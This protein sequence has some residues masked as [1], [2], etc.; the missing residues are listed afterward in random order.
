MTTAL[1]IKPG[2]YRTRGGEIVA[3]ESIKNGIAYTE[4]ECLVGLSWW[5]CNGSNNNFLGDQ[6]PNDRD[7][8]ERIEDE[9]AEDC[10]VKFRKYEY[11]PSFDRTITKPEGAISLV[12]VAGK[13]LWESGPLKLADPVRQ[14]I[15]DGAWRSIKS[16]RRYGDDAREACEKSQRIEGNY[17]LSEAEYD[18]LVGAAATPTADMA[19]KKDNK[20]EILRSIEAAVMPWR[21]RVDELMALC[22]KLEA[23]NESLS[24]QLR[25]R[26]INKE[27]TSTGKRWR[28]SPMV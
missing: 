8:I 3:I 20:T 2:K 13:V 19:E 7:L 25:S 15:S 23:E 4:N 5:A 1:E 12:Q 6:T 26:E 22:D 11:F 24:R 21:A 16:H 27:P 28:W 18:A 10:T 9:K 14:Y 17:V